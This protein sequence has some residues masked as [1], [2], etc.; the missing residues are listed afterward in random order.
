MTDAILTHSFISPG[1]E[2]VAEVFLDNFADGGEIGAG[3]CATL[4]GE[5]IIELTGGHADRA[6]TR[7]WDPGTLVPVYSTT[8]PVAAMMLARLQDQGLL[9]FDEPIGRLWPEFTAHG[10]DVTIAQALSHQAGV[11]GFVNPIDPALW[12][13]PPALAA[14]LAQLEPMWPPGTASGYHPLTFGYIAG[15]LFARAAGMTLGT[16][17]RETV[18]APTGTDFWIGLPP[19]EHGRCA[20]IRKP[21]AAPDLSAITPERRAAFLTKW[22][23]PDRGGAAWRQAELP[24]ANGHGTARSV[25][26][27]YSVFA[28]E[29]RMVSETSGVPVPI[30]SREAVASIITP[31]I[32][33]DDRVLPF[34]CTWGAGIMVNS[35]GKYG[36]N[37]STVGHSGWGGSCALADPDRNLAA[38]YVMNRQ[39]NALIG[40]PRANRLVAALYGCL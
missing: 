16:H 25:A 12:L 5:V 1:F 38:A 6:G 29:G 19:S 4:D 8:K 35:H 26:L 27:L 15:E 36:P 17:L 10:K 20:E 14:A 13:D 40:D 23:A 2:P 34:F 32:A 39:S 30:L 33:N 21:L 9:S 28:N 22:A 11:P 7:P 31:Q 3:F 37:P 18:C 24:A